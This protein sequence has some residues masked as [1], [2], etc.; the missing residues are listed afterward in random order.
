MSHAEKRSHERGKRE[1]KAESVN[2]D[3]VIVRIP[4]AASR[5][6]QSKGGA[7]DSDGSRRGDDKKSGAP[8]GNAW[9][10]PLITGAHSVGAST[11]T[12]TGGN[13][14]PSKGDGSSAD[15]FRLGEPAAGPSAAS[16]AVSSSAGES[17]D[18]ESGLGGLA[19]IWTNQPADSVS[20]LS[21]QSLASQS[22]WD[23]SQGGGER[24]ASLQVC[25]VWMFS[26]L[27]L[28]LGGLLIRSDRVRSRVI[29]E[30]SP[31]SSSWDFWCGSSQAHTISHCHCCL[32]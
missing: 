9:A 23:S 7:P 29:L 27:M 17:L 32:T 16:F 15:A 14:G 2:L 22:I 20:S 19:H 12:G 1:R 5:E 18:Q 13:R 8:V 25:L 11:E 3:D 28:V 21:P 30:S 6:K 10:K 4:K 31:S 26:D 24:S